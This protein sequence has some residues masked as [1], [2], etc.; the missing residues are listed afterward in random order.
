VCPLD[1]ELAPHL[2]E[3]AFSARAFLRG[4]DA[5]ASARDVLQMTQ[6]E[7]SRA[8]EGAPMKRAELR[9]LARSAAGVLG[10]PSPSLRAGS[11]QAALADDVE[12][13]AR[14]LDDDGPPVRE[15]AAWALAL[16]PATPARRRQRRAASPR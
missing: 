11:A 10:N 5:R 8:F 16:R 14:T 4:E 9:G 1:V 15:H 12:L 13:L 3:P 7:F 6:E 2:R